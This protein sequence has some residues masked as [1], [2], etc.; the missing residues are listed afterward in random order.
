MIPKAKPNTEQIIKEI[1]HFR[2]FAKPTEFEI[3]RLKSEA[4][5]I[6]DNIDLADGFALLGMI[7]ALE[8]DEIYMHRCFKNALAHSGAK[9][10][11]HLD[12]YA[13]AL[14]GWGDHK[15]AHQ[16]AIKAYNLV[17]SETALSTLISLSAATGEWDAFEKYNDEYREKFGKDHET[18]KHPMVSH[19]RI[20]ESDDFFFK[21]ANQDSLPKGHLIPE[22]IYNLCRP[23][24]IEAFGTPLVLVFEIIPEFEPEPV[25]S[26]NVQ[27]HGD[28]DEGLEKFDRFEEWY[29]ENGLDLKTNLVIFDIEFVGSRWDSTGAVSSS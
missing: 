10:W 4:I 22:K 5:K 24:L 7:A 2:G 11:W 3:A 28:M 17:R 27:Y 15:G 6:K 8:R 12:S 1:N 16:Y 29:I 20:V 13:I 25:L 14:M 21:H 23:G 18:L 19:S 26:I 9:R